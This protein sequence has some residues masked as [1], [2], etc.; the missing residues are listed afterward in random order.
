M[1]PWCRE[2]VVPFILVSSLGAR[3]V[4]V[5]AGISTYGDGSLRSM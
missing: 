4:S 2:S 3:L 1:E 5:S